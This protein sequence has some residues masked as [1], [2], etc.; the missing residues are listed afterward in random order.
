MFRF[1]GSLISFESRR[2]PKVHKI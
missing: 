1:L 2:S